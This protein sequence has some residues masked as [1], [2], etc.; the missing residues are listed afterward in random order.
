MLEKIKQ[1]PIIAFVTTIIA[2][3]A[4]LLGIWEDLTGEP[5]IPFLKK[6]GWVLD[7]P[8][9]YYF[10][11]IV[12]G[13][14]VLI[15]QVLVIRAFY[16]L[17]KMRSP[18]L[19]IEPQRVV[20]AEELEVL[21]QTVA[22]LQAELAKTQDT[23]PRLTAKPEIIR[24]TIDHARQPGST[25]AGERIKNYKGGRGFFALLRITNEPES[26]N[27]LALAKDV[28]TT[29]SYC[30][31]HWNEIPAFPEMKGAWVYPNHDSERGVIGHIYNEHT[32]VVLKPQDWIHIGIALR[33]PWG[34]QDQCYVLNS[35]S[36]QASDWLHRELYLPSKTTYIKVT[37]GCHGFREI[38][39]YVL[40]NCGAEEGLVLE[41][42]PK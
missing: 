36:L 18:D 24:R 14:M 19:T 32:R 38:H 31:E 37:V 33:Y 30:D 29:I 12:L 4:V 11:V 41:E 28:Y 9:W 3:L 34:D 39:R 27:R 22:E 8:S 2:S 10:S 13:C 20:P 26:L 17:R 35:L 15:L 5:L 23:Q 16:Q 25:F 40:K 6:N 42:F 21:H 1:H 7:M